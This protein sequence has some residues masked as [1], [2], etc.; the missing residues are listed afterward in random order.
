MQTSYETEDKS[1]N[2]DLQCIN[3]NGSSANVLG[4]QLKMLQSN[5][6]ETDKEAMEWKDEANQISSSIIELNNIFKDVAHM[7][8]QQVCSLNFISTFCPIY[9]YIIIKIITNYYLVSAG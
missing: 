4:Q 6:S 8:T 9:T 1:S 2:S 5:R 7:A 3:S